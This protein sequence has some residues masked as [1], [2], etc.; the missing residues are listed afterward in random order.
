MRVCAMLVAIVLT[1]TMPI[2]LFGMLPSVAGSR[3][4]TVARFA[5]LLV[6]R[7]LTRMMALAGAEENQSRRGNKNT[8]LEKQ[9]TH[10]RHSSHPA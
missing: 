2:I 6:I 10:R 1:V 7:Q 9:R 3:V 5:V 4:M 8:E